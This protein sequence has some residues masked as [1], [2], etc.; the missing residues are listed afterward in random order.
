MNRSLHA[1]GLSVSIILL[2]HSAAH[3]FAITSKVPI[4]LHLKIC[5][6]ALYW[7]QEFAMLCHGHFSSS[8]QSLNIDRIWACRGLK[9]KVEDVNR[10]YFLIKV[11]NDGNKA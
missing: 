3:S 1:I 5:A 11:W 4:E 7:Y 10:N 9:A 6:E 2:S 8:V